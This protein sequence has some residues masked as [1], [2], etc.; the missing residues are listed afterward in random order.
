M[1]RKREV[2]MGELKEEIQR[3]GENQTDAE[4]DG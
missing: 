4:C 2:D 1:D 3:G